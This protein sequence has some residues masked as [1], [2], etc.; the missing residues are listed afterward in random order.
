MLFDVSTYLGG[1]GNESVFDIAVD[2]AGNVYVAGST[3]SD[4]FP[5]VQPLGTRKERD[6]FVVNISAAGSTVAAF[7][8]AFGGGAGESPGDV[9]VVKISVGGTPALPEVLGDTTVRVTDSAVVER[10]AMA[11]RARSS[12]S[13]ARRL[14]AAPA[15]QSNDFT[16]VIQRP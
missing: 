8:G 14:A 5:F 9:V 6:A 15:G 7:Q 1:S 12:S 11:R 4:D 10:P 16:L 13:S 3:E 2:A